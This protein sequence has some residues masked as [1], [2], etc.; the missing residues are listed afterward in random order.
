M[1]D[2]FKKIT[3]NNK[4]IKE[5]EAQIENIKVMPFYSIYGTAQERE[6]DLQKCYDALKT[7]LDAHQ[8]LMENLGTEVNKQL[9]YISQMQRQN[10]LTKTA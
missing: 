7:C 9:N 3:K 5:I 6:K 8:L 4:R 1:K 10:T 2:L